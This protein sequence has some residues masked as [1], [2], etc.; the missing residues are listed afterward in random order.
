M[1]VVR[2]VMTTLMRSV[3]A[4]TKAKSE[5]LRSEVEHHLA[6]AANTMLAAWNSTN[7]SFTSRIGECSEAHS[8]LQAQY[9]LTLQEMYDLGRHIA[10]IKLAIKAK[11]APLKVAQ[12]RLELRSH[13]PN[14]E[15]TKD[16][17]QVRYTLYSTTPSSSS[18]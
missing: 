1:S 18:S 14:G 10:S 6:T 5:K 3:T 12:T 9:S 4:E 15:A 13:R 8:K 2:L 17:P 16:M 11:Q 7:Q